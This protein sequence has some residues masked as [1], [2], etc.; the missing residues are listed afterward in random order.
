M[1][2]SILHESVKLG[3]GVEVSAIEDIRSRRNYRKLLLHKY[4]ASILMIFF[5]LLFTR[6]SFAENDGFN[7]IQMR[8]E[9]GDALAQEVLGLRYAAGDGV[10]VDKEKAFKWLSKAAAQGRPK[11]EYVLGRFYGSGDGVPVDRQKAVEWISKAAAQHDADASKWMDQ[12][13]QQEGQAEIDAPFK[14]VNDYFGCAEGWANKFMSSDAT[15]EAIADGAIGKCTESRSQ[16]VMLLMTAGLQ[17][18]DEAMQQK[19]I[20][21]R[22]HIIGMV[23]EER[24]K[25]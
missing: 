19:E 13:H 16:A 7:A 5:I 3:L 11:S 23:L 25:K 22:R 18:A 14:A 6:L 15:P 10:P 4:G 20:E 12:Y 2:K 24:I 17:R 21:L 9:K 1:K 8:A